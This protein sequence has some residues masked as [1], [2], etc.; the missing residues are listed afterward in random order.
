[1]NLKLT[2]QQVLHPYKKSGEGQ[3]INKPVDRKLWDKDRPAINKERL[4]RLEESEKL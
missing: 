3:N 1:M 2:N 4:K